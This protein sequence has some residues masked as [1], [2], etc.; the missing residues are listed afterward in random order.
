MVKLAIPRNLVIAVLK[1]HHV[2]QS[3]NK[4]SLCTALQQNFTFI[5]YQLKNTLSRHLIFDHMSFEKCHSAKLVLFQNS[6]VVT[7]AERHA[8]WKNCAEQRPSS[9]DPIRNSFISK[10]VSCIAR[11]RTKSIDTQSRIHGRFNNGLGNISACDLIKHT[12]WRMRARAPMH[13]FSLI[14]TWA[15]RWLAQMPPVN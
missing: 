4:R 11:Y 6:S 5:A 3:F 12:S 7:L 15:H 13:R 9:F 10:P 14:K 1:I 8:R 2:A